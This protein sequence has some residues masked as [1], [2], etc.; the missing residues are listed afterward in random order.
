M[1]RSMLNLWLPHDTSVY[2]NETTQGAYSGK[3]L[4][5]DVKTRA[6]IRSL[7]GPEDIEWLDWHSKGAF[8]SV[9]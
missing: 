5:W 7:E 6:L 2:W 3:L 9:G 8:Q 1:R 4:V